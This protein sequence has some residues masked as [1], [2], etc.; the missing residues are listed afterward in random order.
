MGVQYDLPQ[1]GRIRV[2]SASG[3]VTIIAEERQDIDVEPGHRGVELKEGGRGRHRH[4]RGLL[5]HLRS[6][7]HAEG[8]RQHRP[9][10]EV[11]TKSG[12]VEVRC[13]LGTDVSVGAISGNVKFVGTLGSV[14]VS[15]VSGG[16]EIDTVTGNLDARAVSGN[17]SVKRCAGR[18][19]V[20]SKSGR[21][22]VE[23]VEGPTHASTISGG[24]EIGTAG[25]DEVELKMV[26]GGAK[27]TVFGEKLPRV[28]FNSLSGKMHCECK[29]GSDFDLKVRSISG[30]LEIK[31]R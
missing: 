1:D 9:V 29:Q 6:H 26:S 2:L 31:G 19:D 5:G 14:K 3:G 21:V 17:I 20:S 28:R 27:V 10:L 8:E 25:S 30:S 15:A 22:R 11:K 23:R 4:H 18:C 7:E 16:I 13:P 24:V 12:T